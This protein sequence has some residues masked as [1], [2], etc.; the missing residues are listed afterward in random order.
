MTIRI[1]TAAPG[2][3]AA[4]SAVI[5]ETLRVSNARDDPPAVI[6][7][8]AA[9]FAPDRVAA[10]SAERQTLVAAEDG[11]AVVGT[12]ALEGS[13]VRS[14]FVRPGWQGRGIGAALMAEVA[15]RAVAAGVPELALR[16]SVT[17]LGFYAR[18]GFEAV[19]DQWDG[20]ERTVVMRAPARR[21]AAPPRGV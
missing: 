10:M 6:E 17:A 14:V 19:R 2:D 15:R 1:R 4:I 13:A 11:G 8:V 12:A 20:E 5:V 21:L 16:S 18:L 9:A 3:A 7:R